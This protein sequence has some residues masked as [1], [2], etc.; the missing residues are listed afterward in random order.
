MLE[1]KRLAT[2]G[3]EVKATAVLAA[4]EAAGV[5]LRDVIQDAVRRDKALDAF[6]AAKG[7]EIQELHARSRD[8]H[9]GDRERDRVVPEGEERRARGA[10]GRARKRAIRPSSSCRP[11]SARRRSASSTSSRHFLEGGDNPDHHLRERRRRRV[12]RRR[13]PDPAMH[14]GP[15]SAEVKSRWRVSSLPSVVSCSSSAASPSSATASTATGSST[16]SPR[17]LA[18]DR[19]AE[20]TV[21]QGRLRRR[22]APTATPPPR[23]ATAVARRRR[24]PQ[25]AHQ[26]RHRDLGRLRGRHRGQ[27]RLRPQQGEHLLQGPRRPGG[28]PRHRR[29]REVARRLPRGRRQGRRRHHVVH[30]RRLRPRVRRPPKP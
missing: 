24:A 23:P 18:P 27:R 17:V 9:R 21:S 29:L 6:E 7:R 15:A 22:D 2:L 16:G 1:S 14:D 12:P 8:P 19:K 26:G 10:E 13:K 30:R 11:A 5:P 28:A 3:R 20:G 4:L 25:P